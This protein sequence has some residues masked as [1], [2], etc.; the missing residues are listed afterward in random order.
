MTFQPSSGHWLCA[1]KA[2]ER[3]VSQG[4][5]E[6]FAL[7]R[8]NGTM[9]NSEIA[10]AVEKPRRAIGPF[11]SRM[12]QEGLIVK[13]GRGLYTLKQMEENQLWGSKEAEEDQL[14]RDD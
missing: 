8:A 14:L 5:Q 11:L 2:A 3:E 4:K 12:V 13:N 1:G 7:L 6:I 9:T 10:Q